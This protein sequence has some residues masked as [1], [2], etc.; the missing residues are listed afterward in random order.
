MS[1]ITVLSPTGKVLKP[2][3]IPDF[4]GCALR[5]SQELSQQFYGLQQ[6]PNK[7]HPT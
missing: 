1:Q 7:N 5:G 4:L 6:I 3:K 2:A